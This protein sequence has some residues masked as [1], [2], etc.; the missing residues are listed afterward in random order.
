MRPLSSAVARHRRAGTLPPARDA[1]RRAGR[2]ESCVKPQALQ[3]P[4]V[5]VKH[6]PPKRASFASARRPD[7]WA[8]DS[9]LSPSDALPYSPRREGLPRTLV[10]PVQEAVAQS[11]ALVTRGATDEEERAMAHLRSESRDGQV[12]RTKG[13][14]LL[15]RAGPGGRGPLRGRGSLKGRRGEDLVFGTARRLQLGGP[16]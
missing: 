3:G 13:T 12:A 6:P 15:P 1:G 2:G 8:L 7:A 10:L 16:V 5:P 9:H 11:T 14:G 4:A